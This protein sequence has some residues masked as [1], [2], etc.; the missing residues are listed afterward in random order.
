MYSWRNNIDFKQFLHW[1]GDFVGIHVTLKIIVLMFW[2]T[3][4]QHM[5]HPE[6]VV[7]VL[8]LADVTVKN[9]HL[10]H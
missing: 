3:F 10:N 9:C 1:S 6:K 4:H 8:T 5:P 7:F 2:T